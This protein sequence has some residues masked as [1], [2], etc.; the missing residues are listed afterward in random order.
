M[1]TQAQVE[2]LLEARQSQAAQDALLQAQAREILIKSR[3]PYQRK[4]ASVKGRLMGM[5]SVIRSPIWTPNQTDTLSM[6]YERF[7]QILPTDTWKYLPHTYASVISHGTWKPYNV[8]VMLSNIIAT[9]ISKGN[10]R[11]I[12]SL[13]PRHGKSWFISQYIPA[14]FLSNWPDQRVILSSYEARFA[15]TWG[16]RV[17]NIIK[18]EGYRCG[19]SLAEDSTAADNWMTTME[20][21]M[22]TAG[23]GGPIT[24]KG[25]NLGLIDDPHKNWQEAQSSTIRKMIQEWFDSTFYTRAE[26]GATIIVLMC[27]TGDTPVLMAN[28]TEKD[29]KNIRPGDMVATYR[30]GVL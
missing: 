14:W 26:P 25:F 23:V 20:G 7:L 17:R 3:T 4:E 24:G 22:M 30:N 12:V 9:A 19:V 29:L 6:G 18:N 13:P 11:I 27:M 8:M 2:K 16:R 28:G 1:S 21:G 10:G 15:A 5:P